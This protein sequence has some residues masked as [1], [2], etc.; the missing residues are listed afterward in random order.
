MSKIEKSD[1]EICGEICNGLRQAI[2]NH[3]TIE[4]RVLTPQRAKD[5][6]C[7]YIAALADQGVIV[8]E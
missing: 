5:F 7:G 4:E 2:D 1:E 6:I 8:D 3:F